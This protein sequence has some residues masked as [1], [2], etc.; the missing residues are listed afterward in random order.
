MSLDKSKRVGRPVRVTS[1]GFTLGQKSLCEIARVVD[2]E[3]QKGPDLIA[4]P[5]CFMGN[6]VDSLD[7]EV[8]KT[9]A[10]LAQKNRVY[11]LCPI[12]RK[13]GQRVFNA[14]VLLERDG[15][16]AMIYDKVYPFWPEMPVKQGMGVLPGT[17]VPVYEA[18]FGRIGILTC[19]DVNFPQL[20]QILAD[21]GAELVIWDSAYSSG[22]SL[23]AHAI[24]H[25][26]YIV[27]ATGARDCQVYDITG[28]RIQYSASGDL[29][30]HT[31]VLDFDR[32][33]F[34]YDFH[35]EKRD[36]LLAEHKDEVEIEQDLRLE[37]WFVL[38]ATKPGV[39]VRELAKQYGLEELP[40]YKVR[41]RKGI[42][43]I[44]GQAIS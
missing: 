20:W 38:R 5:E 17:E 13:D 43:V 6:R 3:A 32:C 19:F 11:L 35:F 28:E 24:N 16:I 23:Q 30:V 2:A 27:S 31:A 44:R 9:M 12:Y 8:I 18:D 37:S 29:N 1:V 26:Y 22:R 21:K 25:N 14:A 40:R 39:S 36:K 15:R 42:D 34:H 41:S 4:L 33:I 10:A 7:G